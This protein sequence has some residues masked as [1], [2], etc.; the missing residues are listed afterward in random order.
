RIIGTSPTK[1][2]GHSSYGGKASVNK[3]AVSPDRMAPAKT[4]RQGDQEA[5]ENRGLPGM[6]HHHSV[7]S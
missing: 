5:I 2:K 3:T 6:S 1:I 7:G 4:R